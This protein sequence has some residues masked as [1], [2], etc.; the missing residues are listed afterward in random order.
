MEKA[1]IIRFIPA[2]IVSV[3][4]VIAAALYNEKFVNIALLFTVIISWSFCVFRNAKAQTNEEQIITSIFSEAVQTQQRNIGTH[5]EE[6]LYDE[7]GKVSEHLTRMGT[8]I[9]DSTLQLQESFS[10]VVDNT[11]EQTEMALNLVSRLSGSE[12]T[13]EDGQGNIAM[14]DFISKTDEILQQNVD[15]LVQISDR[16]IGAIH[17][18]NDMT[19]DLEAMFAS[20]DNVQK[21]ADQTNLLALNAAIEAARAGEVGRGFAVV[22]DEVRSLSQ[23]SSTLNEQI[24]EK[25]KQVKNSMVEV[26][27][28]VGAIASL[29]M[30]G[31][32]EGKSNIDSMLSVVENTNR[33]TSVILHKLTASSSAIG[34]EINNSIRALQFEDIVSQVLGHIQL[35]LEHINEVAVFSH[36]EIAN[37]VDEH[38]LQIAAEKLRQL[39]DS[40]HS[41]N[42]SQKV[43]QNSMDEGEVELF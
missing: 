17:R 5:I 41:Q 33:D 1:T 32:I 8:L 24:R 19:T 11:N 35:R 22:A 39:R 27:T 13:D 14:T 20:L 28:E 4:T 2:L 9:S 10:S 38:E 16:S 40:F 12:S 34:Q 7:T 21:L 15:L 3:L 26:N 37:A 31:A 25:I 6:I 30:N 36:T 43:E 29:D 18:I 23:T 42:I